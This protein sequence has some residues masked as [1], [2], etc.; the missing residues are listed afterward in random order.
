MVIDRLSTPSLT[1]APQQGRDGRVTSICVV[2]P[3]HN[4]GP[5]IARALDSVLRQTVQPAE[6]IVVDDVSKD[7]G[8][9][10]ARSYDGVQVLS[11][12][13]PGPGGYAARNLGIRTARSDFI[14]FLDADDEWDDAHLET[15]DRMIRSSPQDT[16]LFGT[17]Y[18]EIHP[19]GRTIADV[20]RRSG[21]RERVLSF[22]DFVRAW[23]DCGEC[24][25]WTSAIAARRTALIEAGLFPDKRCRRGGDKDLWLRL[26]RQG[27]TCVNPVP[28]AIYFKDSQN[29]VTSLSHD[30]VCHC[31]IE[32]IMTMEQSEPPA[33]R[34][35]LVRLANRETFQYA[36][37]TA[38][39]QRVRRASWKH[40]KPWYNPFQFAVLLG[41]SS[42][43][44]HPL[45][46]LGVR[47]KKLSARA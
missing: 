42:P 44:G 39:S 7:D 30:N 13:R 19:G 9:Q 18:D 11:R 2:I 22:A 6:I 32:T 28:T 29:M 10:I 46:Q 16:V 1:E 36:L 47:L 38:K 33:T 5:H 27:G 35:L 24:P 14:A 41:L 12:D 15:L 25:V 8:P 21:G 23:L 34:N 43:L 26:A 3:L 31:M 17:G 4:K 37:R 40:F 45:A 20:Y